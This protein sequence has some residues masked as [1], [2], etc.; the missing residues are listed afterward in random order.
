MND[1]LGRSPCAGRGGWPPVRFGLAA[2]LGATLLLMACSS[3]PETRYYDIRL[4]DP[5]SIAGAPLGRIIVDEVAV[6]DHLD[7][8][9]IFYRSSAYEA[10]YY[11]YHLWVRPLSTSL[12]AEIVAYLIR[13]G[14]FEEVVGPPEAL[15]AEGIRLSVTVREFAEIDGGGDVWTA[16]VD[17]AF[18]LEDASARRHAERTITRSVPIAP[19]N[20]AGT[21]A[22]L[23]QAWAEVAEVAMDEILAFTKK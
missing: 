8:P 17:V 14:R 23:N 11:G 7:G 5:G 6:P 22:A 16:D 10:G 4:P 21:V 9:E 3:P 19:R 1:D 12:S 20:A 15:G 13:T 18:R 2:A